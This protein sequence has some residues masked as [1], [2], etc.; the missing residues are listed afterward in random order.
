MAAMPLPAPTLHTERLR[1]RAVIDQDA[2]ALVAMHSDPHV[3]RYWDAPPWTEPSRAGAFVAACR[4]MA[5][6]GTGTR[7]AVNRAS[8]AAFLGWCSL[9]RWD[10]DHRSAALGYCLG[11]DAWG[12]GYATEAAGALLAWGFETLDLNRVQ[13]EVDTRN[14]A[15]ARLRPGRHA[16]RGLRRRRGGLGL[17]GLRA[18][19][20][21]VATRARVPAPGLA[22]GRLRDRPRP[23][24]GP[25]R[26]RGRRG[27]CGSAP[28]RRRGRARGR[29]PDRS[30]GPPPR[31][32]P[33]PGT[34]PGG[35]R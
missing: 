33:A 2:D 17:V 11:A 7:L 13:A 23:R 22:A 12:H 34:A 28:T 5:D 26:G 30:A 14:A 8:D 15:S 29:G 19:P 18:A 27:R 6:E 25:R 4:R 20:A 31:R 35:R 9:T 10:P 32:S 3:L 24:D 16:A 1:L 21:R